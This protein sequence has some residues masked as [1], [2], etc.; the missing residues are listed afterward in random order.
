M[1]DLYLDLDGQGELYLQLTRAL[2]RAVQEGR[3][4]PGARLPSTRALAEQLAV[5]R[6]TVLS[7]YELLRNEHTFASRL[8][9]GTFV[10]DRVAPVTKHQTGSH[11]TAA[12][13]Y[14]QRLR[15]LPPP[16]LRPASP[17]IRYDLQYGEPIVDP[18]LTTAWRQAL[19]R[20]VVRSDLRYAPAAGHR[21]LREAISVLVGRRRGI[22]CSADD[23]VVVSGAQQALSLALRVLVDEDEPVVVEDPSYPLAAMAI[24]AHGAQLKT[25]PVDGEGLDVAQLPQEPPR[26]ILVTPSHQ[27]PSG[28]VM[29]L[30]RRRELLEFAARQGTW[31]IEDDYDGEFRFAGAPQPALRSLDHTGR[32]IYV[33]SFSK[34]LFPTLRLGFVVCPAGLREDLMRA[35]MLDDLGCPG[36]AQLALLDLITSGAY[37]RH[38]RHA[39]T[40]LRRRRA[41]LLAGLARHCSPHITVHDSG[42]GMHLVGWLRGWS[43]HDVEPLVRR[44]QQRGVG[45]QAIGPFFDR[46]PAPAGLLLGYAGLS[47]KQI[48]AATAILGQC[49]RERDVD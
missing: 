47:A 12:S 25:V 1:P 42:A 40:E 15:H 5:S 6:N 48:T 4:R 23:V 36:M 28:V 29:S 45:V 49:L 32:V 2:R 22:A 20:A 11:E 39:L 10:A 24:R 14:V 46:Q 37:E 16:Q 26:A 35:K 7:A 17:S 18:R 21:A 44:A 33:G 43:Q 8:G 41:A 3:L 27:F 38:L 19:S 13:R 31:V 34:V 9:S 30:R